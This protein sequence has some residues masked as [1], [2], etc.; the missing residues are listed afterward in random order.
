[1]F[2]RDET[3]EPDGIGLSRAGGATGS[4]HTDRLAGRMGLSDSGPREASAIGPAHDPHDGD[5]LRIRPDPGRYSG[6][7]ECARCGVR[8]RSGAWI[9][10]VATLCRRRDIDGKLYDRAYRQ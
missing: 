10:S 8:S 3:H 4:Y 2:M 5:R 1:M 6:P 9:S 7:A